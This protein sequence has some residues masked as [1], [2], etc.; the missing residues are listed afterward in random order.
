MSFCDL[1]YSA[2][3]V[4][5]SLSWH[6]HCHPHKL[7]DSN[8]VREL[9]MSPADQLQRLD[10][11]QWE[12]KDPLDPANDILAIKPSLQILQLNVEG[13]SAAKQTIVSS[14]LSI[15]LSWWRCWMAEDIW[16]VNALDNKYI[17]TGQ[18]IYTF[19]HLLYFPSTGISEM[20]QRQ[21]CTFPQLSVT[22]WVPNTR[23]IITTVERQWRTES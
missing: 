9:K 7:P 17:T 19:L 5:T 22:G 6:P 12:D 13:L 3:P 11:G 1:F 18:K 23:K 10:R 4:S 15:V 2:L 21:Q 8:R 14:L 20:T 16:L